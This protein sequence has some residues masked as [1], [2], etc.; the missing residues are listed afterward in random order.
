M[1]IFGLTNQVGRASNSIPSNLQEGCGRSTSKDTIH[2]L[3]M[4]RGSC[5]EVIA[6]MD[7]G[8]RLG[9]STQGAFEES[10]TRFEGIRKMLSGLIKRYNGL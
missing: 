4:A 10:I 2:Y 1:E 8:C 3:T 6:Q 9:Y 7:I 5:N